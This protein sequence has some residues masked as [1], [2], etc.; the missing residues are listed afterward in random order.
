[1]SSDTTKICDTG[2][3]NKCDFLRFAMIYKV[4]DYS[5]Q[6]KRVKK[7][8][9][10]AE[11]QW[12]VQ[13]YN[14]AGGVDGLRFDYWEPKEINIHG[15]C[16]TCSPTIVYRGSDTDEDSMKRDEI[17]VELILEIKKDG[18]TILD[19][20]EGN[21]SD[22]LIYT[23]SEAVT[24]EIIKDW[25]IEPIIPIS[26]VSLKVAAGWLDIVER[27]QNDTKN[28]AVD[29]MRD[30]L[31]YA[32]MLERD[33]LEDSAEAVNITGKIGMNIY[34][35]ENGDWSAN[36][37]QGLGLRSDYYGAA[38]DKTKTDI[39]DGKIKDFYKSG[40]GKDRKLKTIY[41]IGHSLGGGLASANTVCLGAYA[42]K[43]YS[44][45]GTTYNA[46][47]LHQN[48]VTNNGGGS[49]S[50]ADV[51]SYSVTNEILTTLQQYPD[52]MPLVGAF[53][54]FAQK[55]MVPAIQKPMEK[56]GDN[57]FNN[58][59]IQI[60]KTIERCLRNNPQNSSGFFTD[61][62]NSLRSDLLEYLR[63]MTDNTPYNENFE[64]LIPE[65]M[66]FFGVRDQIEE[67]I[68]NNFPEVAD[69]RNIEKN[70]DILEEY[71]KDQRWDIT[72]NLI[73][74][75]VDLIS[76]SFLAHKISSD[77]KESVELHLMPSVY[78]NYGKSFK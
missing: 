38:I 24:D 78:K 18:E 6:P 42:A 58:K 44:V 36:V 39:F 8:L 3:F 32:N 37:T 48:T 20:A 75:G 53:F 31:R 70:L 17:A 59:D 47:G 43:E 71:V 65:N 30:P 64:N 62:Y 29:I 28:I 10:E 61:L 69:N 46:A 51:K 77:M 15:E 63:N 12:I 74:Q 7:I 54:T 11:E 19:L 26:D 5:K 55:S 9:D 66:S 72:D 13:T 21:I 40:A 60:V 35:G 68:K 34:M 52:K 25:N 23:P 56:G 27:M 16:C 1:M 2:R 57:I 22:G 4:Y 49:I 67:H 76:L 45:L 50:S 33:M 41:C 14:N 73:Y